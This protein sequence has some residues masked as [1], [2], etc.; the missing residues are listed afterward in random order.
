MQTRVVPAGEW[1]VKDCTCWIQT[2]AL[3]GR[4]VELHEGSLGTARMDSWSVVVLGA[5]TAR[6]TSPVA[7]VLSSVES[8]V[9][10]S[11]MLRD[12]GSLLGTF[13]AFYFRP[14]LLGQLHARCSCHHTPGAAR[15]AHRSLIINHSTCL[16]PPS[17]FIARLFLPVFN[18][19]SLPFL[20]FTT[21]PLIR[22]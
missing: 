4:R 5:V 15:T 20:F 10:L 2:V 21:R 17:S 8:R 16:R 12:A 22:R 7:A 6:R 11:T 1:E 18:T 13:L 3:R 9:F 19:R 14:G